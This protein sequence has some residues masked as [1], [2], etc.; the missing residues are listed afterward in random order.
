MISNLVNLQFKLNGFESQRSNLSGTS[1]S[2]YRIKINLALKSFVRVD[3]MKTEILKCGI[4]YKN[5]IHSLILEFYEL[6]VEDPQSEK[7]KSTLAELL[8]HPKYG[9]VFL[10][11][12]INQFIG[13]AI[14]CFGFSLEYGGR[15]AFIDEL[16]IRKD[17]RNKKIG[18]EVLDYLCKYSRTTGLKALH[19]EVKEKHKEAERLYERK[20]F[21]LKSG[22]FLSLDLTR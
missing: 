6:S 11:K 10:I 20:K 17:Y 22:K 16:Y 21:L 4:E 5:E 15:D 3:C 9:S 1:L 7:L 18:S 12:Q 8:A 14:L 13:Y 19:I 2:L